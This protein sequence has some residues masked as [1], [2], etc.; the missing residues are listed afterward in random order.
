LDYDFH[1]LTLPI[2]TSSI[3]LEGVSVSYQEEGQ[4]SRVAADKN[5]SKGWFSVVIIGVG[6]IHGN[7]NGIAL[8]EGPGLLG[9]V[10]A[11]CNCTGD[12]AM[13]VGLYQPQLK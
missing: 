12:V 11:G 7:L 4:N 10:D 8:K 6:L 1:T 3:A 9:I 2:I 5:L 13:M